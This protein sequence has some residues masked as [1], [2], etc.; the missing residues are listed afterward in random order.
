MNTIRSSILTTSVIIANLT[1]IIHNTACKVNY[2]NIKN[3][4][5][6]VSSVNKTHRWH[7]GFLSVLILSLFASCNSSED[8]GTTTEETNP[9]NL[10]NVAVMKFSLKNDRKIMENLDSVFFSIDL[11]HGVIF[12]ADS[13]P[14]DTKI[15][16]LI[17]VIK[18]TDFVTSAVINMEGG[19]TRT[20]TVDYKKTPNDSID[21]TGRV[22][23]TLQ[24]EDN[25]SKEY[26]IK[27]NVHKENPDSIV[28]HSV[29]SLG[30]PY[31]SAAPVVSKAVD[32]KGVALLI[33]LESDNSYSL[34]RSSD[35]FE[36]QWS[37]TSLN[38]NFTPDIHSLAASTDALYMLS[39]TGELYSS[40]D[41]E[42]WTDTGESWSTIIG[43]YNETVI[44]IR[45]SGSGLSFAQYPQRN[46]IPTSPEQ[47]FP[48]K[49]F[50][51]FVSYNNKWS[52]SPIAFLCGGI[53]ADGSYSD[54][55]WG[56]DGYNWVKLSTGNLPALAG[57]VL[58]DYYA[59][60]EVTTGRKD[61]F[62]VWLL[63][64]G[65]KAD[66]SLSSEVF[67]SFDNGVNWL[68][69]SSGLQ[70]PPE[71]PPMKCWSSIVQ[72][73]PFDT[74]LS[75]AWKV[76][77]SRRARPKINWSVDG[78]ILSWEAPYIYLLG[79][80]DETGRQNNVMYRGILNRLR[81]APII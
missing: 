63:M 23:L 15:D 31:L 55:T 26:E 9:V 36:N 14:K 18:Y 79:G 42:I 52:S 44:G 51:N 20:G 54:V 78:D 53:L 56:F 59:Y 1:V 48:V 21:F 37:V 10:P 5:R 16:K 30:L 11:D 68:R 4:F 19:T 27:V 22:T 40:P 8:A 50:S 34:A 41:G 61:E 29:A 62:K 38:V 7:I 66:G 43:G 57:V 47:D 60:R 3:R 58:I 45:T 74:S 71:V 35:L 69:A 28:W 81:F 17:P 13:L 77:D 12:N 6:Q 2:L 24:S 80:F 39:S 49:D 72:F 76:Q 73:T 75:D 64:G 32:F 46:L 33:N 67:L 25:I 70:L 65:E